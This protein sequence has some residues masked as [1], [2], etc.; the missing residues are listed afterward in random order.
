MCSEIKLLKIHFNSSSI[1]IQPY[2]NTQEYSQ[3]KQHYYG[4][5][6][7]KHISNSHIQEHI[8]DAPAFFCDTAARCPI[9]TCKRHQTHTE[10]HQNTTMHAHIPDL[11][12]TAVHSS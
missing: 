3:T 12:T 7:L 9:L 11:T 5:K 8:A 10:Y 1:V 4:V 6:V 2:M